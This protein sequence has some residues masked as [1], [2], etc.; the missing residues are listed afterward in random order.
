V[1][2]GRSKAP[3]WSQT[4]EDLADIFK[5]AGFEWRMAGCCL[6]MNPDQLAEGEHAST[7][8]PEL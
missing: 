6:A 4:E 2:G 3:V 1:R 7:S 8:N 5:D